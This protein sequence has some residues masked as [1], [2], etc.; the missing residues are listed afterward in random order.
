[1][2]E[3]SAIAKGRPSPNEM[4]KKIETN[5]ISMNENVVMKI[6]VSDAIIPKST[7]I[8]K[9]RLRLQNLLIKYAPTIIEVEAPRK[10][11]VQTMYN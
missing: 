10:L 1:L 9:K 7:H 6:G 11:I 8:I 4:L 5:S 2:L 3:N